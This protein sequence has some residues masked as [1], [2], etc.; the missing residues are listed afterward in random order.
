MENVQTS[1]LSTDSSN[2]K[3]KHESNLVLEIVLNILEQ[4][5]KLILLVKVC[6]LN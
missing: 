2:A 1:F 4:Q 5:K 3:K 6:L